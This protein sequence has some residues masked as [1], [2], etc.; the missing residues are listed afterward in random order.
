[1]S[2]LVRSWRRA[3]PV[4]EVVVEGGGL[5]LR[6]GLLLAF[7]EPRFSRFRAAPDGRT[8]VDTGRLAMVLSQ[9]EGRDPQEVAILVEARLAGLRIPS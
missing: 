5:R 9:L 7:W 4:P 3:Y 2:D 8:G 6:D 1:M